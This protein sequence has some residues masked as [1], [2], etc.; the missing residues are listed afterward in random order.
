[1]QQEQNKRGK[2]NQNQNSLVRQLSGVQTKIM[3]CYII[4][5]YALFK[6]I[7]E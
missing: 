3:W 1:M 2:E 6:D 4:E 7:A 5:K